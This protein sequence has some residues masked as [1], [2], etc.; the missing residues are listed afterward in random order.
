MLKIF[1]GEVRTGRL[2]RLP[3]VACFVTL[4]VLLGL[5]LFAGVMLMGFDETLLEGG[6]EQ[7]QKAFA[8][9]LSMPVMLIGGLLVMFCTLASMNIMAKRLRDIGLP[10]W[11]STLGIALL[12]LILSFQVAGSIGDGFQLLVLLALLLLPSG[13]L[14]KQQQKSKD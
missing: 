13:I 8:D 6:A 9:N 14:S 11:W 5:L 2:K 4:N 12:S 3:Y 7:I 10:G 1:W